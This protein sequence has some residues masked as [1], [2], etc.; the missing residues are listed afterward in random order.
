LLELPNHPPG[1]SALPPGWKPLRAGSRGGTRPTEPPN[2]LSM[3]SCPIPAKESVTLC[4]NRSGLDEIS[5]PGYAAGGKGCESCAIARSP[6]RPDPPN[7]A[8][9]LRSTGSVDGSKRQGIHPW[10]SSR[11]AV[12]ANLAFEKSRTGLKTD[13]RRVS[14][15]KSRR[16]GKIRR[17]KKRLHRR[18]E[19]RAFGSSMV[20]LFGRTFKKSWGCRG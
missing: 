17:T 16:L 7:S 5:T 4:G 13:Y 1:W 8:A 20:R 2:T 14:S 10:T 12:Y 19:G 18:S 11:Q 15:R 9:L 3:R 6:T